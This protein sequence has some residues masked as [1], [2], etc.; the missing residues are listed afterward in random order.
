MRV[1][2]IGSSK[3]GW[4][5]FETLAES[6]SVDLVGVITNPEQFSISYSDSQVTNVLHQ[7]MASVAQEKKLP[8]YVMQDNMHEPELLETLKSWQPELIIVVGWYHMIPKPIREVA[9]CLGMHASLLPDY[10]GGAPLVWAMINQESKTGISLFKIEQGVDTGDLLGQKSTPIRQDDTIATLYARIETLGI[11]LLLEQLA[12]Y[13]NGQHQWIVQ[14]G[15]E[16]RTFPQR[17]PK[18]GVIDW[19]QSVTAIDHFIRAQTKP[20]PGA[21]TEWQN[22][23]LIIWSAEIEQDD[24]MSHPPG[25]VVL[26]DGQPCFAAQDGWVRPIEV[27]YQEQEQVW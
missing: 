1:A 21:F 8:C 16:A 4:R 13:Q 17:S 27:H 12:L 6:D 11:E 2:F 19:Q 15:A 23:K 5:C 22:E 25:S 14:D 20:Y 18:D 24:D 10:R 3:F 26:I 9:L 7:D